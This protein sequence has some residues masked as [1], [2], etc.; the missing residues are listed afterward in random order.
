MLSIF[1][2]YIIIIVI[3][4]GIT[5]VP[6]LAQLDYLQSIKKIDIHTHV[7][8]DAPYLREI[9]DEYNFKFSTICTGGRNLDRMNKQRESA[10]KISNE[11]PRYYAWFTTFDLTQREDPNWTENVIKQ[12]KDDFNNGALG[13]KVWKEIGMSIKDS[14]GNYIMIDDP[15]FS[16]IFDFIAKEGKAVLAHIGEPIHSWMPPHPHRE[17]IPDS[18]WLKHPEFNFWDKPDFPSYN[19]IIA[20][21]DHVLE[22]HPDLKFIGA[23]LGSLEFDVEEIAKRLDKHPNFAVEIGGR[24]RYLMWQVRGKVREFFIKYQDRLFYSTDRNGGPIKKNGESMSE[25]D[26]EKS[27]NHI[28]ERYDLFSRYYATEEEIPWG[29]YVHGGKPYPKATYSVTGL[30]LPKEVL[31]KL[32]YDNAVKWLPGINKDF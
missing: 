4:V 32:Y 30:A 22:N 28:L 25:K 19:D 9:L 29:S 12:L 14:D 10:K 7:R 21:R 15:I 23:H 24:T 26:I 13:V 6:V 8:G 17:G 1:K 20:A 5:S 16:P 27:R 18:Y 3:L 11:N 2:N 31:K